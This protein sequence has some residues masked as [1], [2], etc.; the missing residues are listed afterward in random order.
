MQIRKLVHVLHGVYD[1]REVGDLVFELDD[2]VRLAGGVRLGV[3]HRFL[4]FVGC[5]FLI[6]L[7]DVGNRLCYSVPCTSPPP[8]VAG[9]TR[10]VYRGRIVEV[11]GHAHV[12]VV[13]GHAHVLVQ[14]PG[15]AQENNTRQTGNHHDRPD[16]SG[17]LRYSSARRAV[18]ERRALVIRRRGDVRCLDVHRDVS[19]RAPQG[20]ACRCAVRWI[21][22]LNAFFPKTFNM[23]DFTRHLD[24][25][26][27]FW[28]LHGFTLLVKD[29]TRR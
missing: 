26:T 11:P 3:I 14:V 18:D 7:H 29:I 16:P 10:G 4:K 1:A 21:A 28:T 2:L 23:H 27:H 24:R 25:A 15:H 20:R 19:K 9:V 17:R 12:L 5:A 6:K 8:E 22:L 13:P